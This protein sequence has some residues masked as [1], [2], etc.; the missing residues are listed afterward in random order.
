MKP[1]K[2]EIN[3]CKQV[4]AR[5]RKRIN[6]GDQYWCGIAH[7]ICLCTTKKI[8]DRLKSHFPLWTIS[9]CQSWLEEKGFNYIFNFKH[10][11]LGGWC[12]TAEDRKYKKV[13]GEGKT[14]LASCL[15]AVLAVLEEGK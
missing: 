14:R 1:T 3:L 12:F 2:E 11:K 13:R 10:F 4:A 9:D 8:E 7:K 5:Y 6:Y 15:K